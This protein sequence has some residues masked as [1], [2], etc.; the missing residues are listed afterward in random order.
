MSSTYVN[1]A[2]YKLQIFPSNSCREKTSLD[3]YKSLNATQN[4]DSITI[5][6]P[7]TKNFDGR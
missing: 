4:K 6:L 7:A 1:T 5:K 2:L 3:L